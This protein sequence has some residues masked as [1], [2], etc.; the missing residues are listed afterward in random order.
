MNL[1]ETL[2]QKTINPNIRVNC[3]LALISFR[4]TQEN[5]VNLFKIV[6]LFLVTVF[7]SLANALPITVEDNLLSNRYL[8]DRGSLAGSFDL[9]TVISKDPLDSYDV[10]SG[11]IVF[12]LVDDRDVRAFRYRTYGDYYYS[13][14]SQSGWDYDSSK[15]W[16]RDWRYYTRNRNDVYSYEGEIAQVQADGTSGQRTSWSSRSTVNSRYYTSYTGGYT[17]TDRL[18]DFCDSY[19]WW[20]SHCTDWDASYQYNYRYNRDLV[21]VSTVDYFITGITLDLSASSLL[22]LSQT[23]TLGFDVLSSQG[24]FF[25]RNARLLANVNII[26]APAAVPEPSVLAM[27]LLGVFGLGLFR[28]KRK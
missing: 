25:L 23:G 5:F 20:S 18:A 3:F 13:G 17:G 22:S 28:I 8:A 26:K 24:D 2:S 12:D 4:I 16:K 19:S 27:L 7:S 6:F 14:G 9:S 10:T 21:T 11:R 1:S 15:R